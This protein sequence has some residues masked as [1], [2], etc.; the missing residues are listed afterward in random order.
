MKQLLNKIANHLERNAP[1]GLDA[2][3]E[4]ERYFNW[5][6]PV[7]Y[8]EFLLFTNGLEGD[9]VGNYLVLWNVKELVELNEAYYVKEFVSNIIIFG[10]DGEEDAFGFDTANAKI[11]KL[12]FI[13]MGHIPNEIVAD[14]FKDFLSSQIKENKS[15]FKR[16]FG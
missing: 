14:T 10:S 15:L 2:I 12:P 4:L 8:K 13:G 16:L 9:T 11:V 5:Q 7:D 3:E 1:A 6:F